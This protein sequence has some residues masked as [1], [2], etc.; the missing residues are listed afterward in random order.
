M[1]V[2]MVRLIDM[3]KDALLREIGDE[4]ELIF[5]YGSYLKGTTNKYSD[6]DI[7]YVPV[8]ESTWNSI[9]VLVD[10]M[11]VDLYPIHWSRFGANG[12]F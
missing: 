3:L 7:S 8:H 1:A 9:T 5:Q 4:V 11:M 6:L 10:D 12:Q 2:D